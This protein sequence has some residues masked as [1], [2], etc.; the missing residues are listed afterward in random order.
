M[1][2]ILFFLKDLFS[3]KSFKKNDYDQTLI[4]IFCIFVCF[5]SFEPLISFSLYFCFLHSIRHLNDEK[6]ILKFSFLKLIKATLPLTFI[7][8]FTIVFIYYFLKDFE[9]AY[10]SS[11][12]IILSCLTLPHMILVSFSKT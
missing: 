6:N 11:L 12:F 5:W 8:S 7:T 2:L 10:V 9:Y 4:E 3:K 1:I